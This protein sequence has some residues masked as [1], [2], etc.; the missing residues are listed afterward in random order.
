MGMT[1][2]GKSSRKTTRAALLR[3]L[4]LQ[5]RRMVPSLVWSWWFPGP[6]TGCESPRR[7]DPPSAPLAGSGT[8]SWLGTRPLTLSL[9]GHL[10]C[11]ALPHRAAWVTSKAWA[12]GTTAGASTGAVGPA[13]PCGA[14]RFG[15]GPFI[16]LATAFSAAASACGAAGKQQ[17]QVFS[18]LQQKGP[19]IQNEAPA[20]GTT[21]YRLE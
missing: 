13:R 20:V 4:V 14:G 11:R 6:A 8:T 1:N 10:R 12:V 2:H 19:Q 17:S 18:A 3:R 9:R 7:A 16:P 15:G 21:L 5:M